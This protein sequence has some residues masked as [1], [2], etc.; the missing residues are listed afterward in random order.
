ML[1]RCPELLADLRDLLAQLRRLL[2]SSLQLL[3][4]VG[5]V[6]DRLIQLPARE[7]RCVSS[8]SISPSTTARR[9]VSRVCCDAMFFRSISIAPQPAVDARQPPHQVEDRRLVLLD[10]LVDR[11]AA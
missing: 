9:S 5:N 6:R 11:I 7:R 10:F 2:P 1:L 3:L 4:P 8:A